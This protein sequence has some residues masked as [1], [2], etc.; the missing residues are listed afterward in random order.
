VP[1]N[2]GDAFGPGS[3]AEPA[4]GM[5]MAWRHSFLCGSHGSCVE[6]ASLSD[7]GVAIRDGKAGAASPVLTF[8]QDE[9]AAFVAGVKAGEF[10]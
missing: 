7:G 8:T 10:G 9:W 6:I 2:T 5:E 3:G 4:K 1:A